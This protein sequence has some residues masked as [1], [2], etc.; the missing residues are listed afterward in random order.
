MGVLI[1]P[2]EITWPR[3]CFYLPPSDGISARGG[4]EG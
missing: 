3:G 4:R 2:V 1:A